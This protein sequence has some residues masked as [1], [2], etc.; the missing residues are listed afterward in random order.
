MIVIA[1]ID[2]SNE[3]LVK[4]LDKGK[5]DIDDDDADSILLRVKASIEHS[6]A[7]IPE[8]GTCDKKTRGNY[9]RINCRRITNNRCCC[10]KLET[11]TNVKT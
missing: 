9:D 4:L 3:P 10:E 5:T 2:L 7:K 8:T 1:G 11:I 6:I